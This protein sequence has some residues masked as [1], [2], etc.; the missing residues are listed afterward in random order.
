MSQ[1]DGKSR[2]DEASAAFTAFLTK[3]GGKTGLQ[4]TRND[5]DEQHC[6][7]DDKE[8]ASNKKDD[9]ESSNIS[10]K[11]Y[12]SSFVLR[13]LL[14]VALSLDYCSHSQV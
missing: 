8:N 4:K 10:T 12:T 1:I 14:L 11:K 2:R 9:D 3:R 7:S 5:H 6:S 13:L